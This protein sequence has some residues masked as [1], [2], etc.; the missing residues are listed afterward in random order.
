VAS[1]LDLFCFIDA[2]GHEIYHRCPILADE[3]RVKAP[4]ETIFGYSSTCDPTIITGLMP[5]DHGHFSFYCYDPAGSPFRWLR[6]LSLLPKSIAS[7]GRVRNVIS[8]WVRRRLG[9]TGYFQLYAMPFE[10]IHLFD[11]SEKRDLYLPGGINSGATTIFDDLRGGG[12]PFFVADWQADELSNL[13]SLRSAIDGGKARFAYLYMA[14]M[15]AILHEHGTDSPHV[16]DKMRWYER[17]LRELMEY[18]RERYDAV[19]LYVFSDHGMTDVHR[20]LP[21]MEIVESL[22]LRFGEDFAAVYDSTMAR[23]WF[24]SE[25]AR[26]KTI[27]FL[28]TVEGGRI[29]TDADLARWGA[30]FPD[31]RYGELFFL[32]DPGT[33]LCPGHL[34]LK[35]LA[36]MHGYDPADPDSTAFFGSTR[37]EAE[38]PGGMPRRLDDLYR[39]M[40]GSIWPT[41]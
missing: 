20:T 2:L 41:Q 17:Q 7:R 28:A 33:L 10:I 23:F 15:D 29:L 35:P 37:P 9:Y 16:A 22:G 11:Y 38:I 3:L 18:A 31:R 13:A 12:V 8:R 27:D 39:V 21:L 4:L 25:D 1:E 32:L 36:G 24:L 14:A 34:G 30:D 40:R 6:P 26:R 5:R 19:H